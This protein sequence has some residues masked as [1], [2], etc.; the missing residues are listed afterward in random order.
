MLSGS[1]PALGICALGALVG[2]GGNRLAPGPRIVLTA[3]LGAPHSDN[4]LCLVCREKQT[5]CHLI[6]ISRAGIKILLSKF[7]CHPL[8]LNEPEWPK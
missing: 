4:R 6:G 3:L 1:E 8:T 2:Q 7:Y 5:A